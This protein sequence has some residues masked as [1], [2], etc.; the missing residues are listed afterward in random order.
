[1]ET[2]PSLAQLMKFPEPTRQPVY[3]NRA[4]QGLEVQSVP[5][6]STKYDNMFINT[7]VPSFMGPA[8]TLHKLCDSHHQQFY[9]KRDKTRYR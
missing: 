6:V 8:V 4:F 7:S 3:R 1:M 9:D 2:R 5:A